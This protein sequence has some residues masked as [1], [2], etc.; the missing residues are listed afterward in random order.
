M[1]VAKLLDIVLWNV[2]NKLRLLFGWKFVES[3]Y[4]GAL[5]APCQCSGEVLC[6]LASLS[7]KAPALEKAE[8]FGLP[9]VPKCRDDIGQSTFA[10]SL[11]AD[12]SNKVWVQWDVTSVEPCPYAS[13]GSCLGDFNRVNIVGLV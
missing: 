6:W 11:V 13:L 9:R 5:V 2:T 7:Q 12:N 4:F 8:V 1:G 3:S 10:A